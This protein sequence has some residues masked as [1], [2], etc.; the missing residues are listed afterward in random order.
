MMV[1]KDLNAFIEEMEFNTSL[2]DR[3]EPENEVPTEKRVLISDPSITKSKL[4][5]D[6]DREVQP[7]SIA[8]SHLNQKDTDLASV[9][10]GTS[11]SNNRHIKI[12]A[13]VD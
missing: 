13:V 3:A 7:F 12:Q 8:S 6:E 11:S 9:S 2:C 4:Q 1:D 5:Y 10:P